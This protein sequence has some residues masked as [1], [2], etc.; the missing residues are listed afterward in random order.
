MRIKEDIAS[1]HLFQGNKFT[2]V[3]KKVKKWT[4]AWAS[5]KKT[6]VG[7]NSDSPWV[8]SNVLRLW[9]CRGYQ[10]NVNGTKLGPKHRAGSPPVSHCPWWV[11]LPGVANK[12]TGQLDFISN[13]QW[14]IKMWG[15]KACPKCISIYFSSVHWYIPDPQTMPDM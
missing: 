3:S 6:V 1:H 15:M 2:L 13:R 10:C 11:G 14:I 12:N 7:G 9:N 5:N 8:T 4:R